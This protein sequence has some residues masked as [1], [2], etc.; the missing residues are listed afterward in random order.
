[1]S[2]FHIRLARGDEREEI[3]EL[4]ALSARKLSE[5]FYTS[6]Q[7]EGALHGAFG[8]DTSLIADGSYF[9]AEQD[10]RVIGCGGWSKRRTLF[11]GDKYSVRDAANLDPKTEPTRIRAFFVHPNFARRGVA[12]AILARCEDA[13]E[14]AGF[15]AFEL[16]A[17]L[18]GVP[19]Y[20]ACGYVRGA[21]ERF[22]LEDK[23]E[24][25]F[26]RMT[27]IRRR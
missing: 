13:A 11:G 22:A 19:F 16:M 24:I 5:N 26:V 23:V 20:E 18:P 2:D 7:V 17:T 14:Q 3:E 10:G 8:V 25:E 15:R 9:V 21:T 1:M 4:I 12:R 27:K 6:E